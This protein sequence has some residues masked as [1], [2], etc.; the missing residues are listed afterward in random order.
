MDAGRP[1]RGVQESS[2]Q[3]MVLAQTRVAEERVRNGWTLDVFLKGANRICS[4]IECWVC[5]CV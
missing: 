3:E 1:V 5:L 4:R 2:R